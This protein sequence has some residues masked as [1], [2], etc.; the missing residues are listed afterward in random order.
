MN[1]DED[2]RGR[3]ARR[4]AK[5]LR[6]L[7]A[8]PQQG[9]SAEQ[10]CAHVGLWPR[11]IDPFSELEKGSVLMQVELELGELVRDGSISARPMGTAHRTRMVYRA[12]QKHRPHR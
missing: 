1:R 8:R 4:R 12:S 3:S 5:I 6:F 2:E 9:F 10:L 7:G 11:P